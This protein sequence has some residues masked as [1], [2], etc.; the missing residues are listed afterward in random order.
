MT[1][2]PNCGHEL[3][4]LSEDYAIGMRCPNCEFAFVTSYID[5]IYEDQA[6][7]EVYLIEGNSLTKEN[8]FDL[9]FLT[10]LNMTE[11]RELLLHKCP[12]KVF[13]GCAYEVKELRDRLDKCNIKYMI[14]PDF[15]Y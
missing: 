12:Y 10:G 4:N 2:C 15:N 5:P 7:Y 14:K 11:L 9:N 6:I 8:Y 13:S 3:I 1:K